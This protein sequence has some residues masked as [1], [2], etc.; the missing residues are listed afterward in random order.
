MKTLLPQGFSSYV[1]SLVSCGYLPVSRQVCQKS[2]RNRPHDIH[3]TF[4][5]TGK[6]GSRG[7]IRDNE[8]RSLLLLSRIHAAAVGS[9]NRPT[10]IR[11]GVSFRSDRTM[12]VSTG[13]TK[14]RLQSGTSRKRPGCFL[15]EGI[16]CVPD[17]TSHGDFPSQ[18]HMEVL[19]C[20]PM[21]HE[22]QLSNPSRQS[23]LNDNPNWRRNVARKSAGLPRNWVC[24]K[25]TTTFWPGCSSN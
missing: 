23:W 19:K 11:S 1:H 25:R 22:S 2:A 21:L 12:L 24:S 3:R 4:S 16:F 10:D 9:P 18:V 15:L 5:K 17:Q 7:R 20:L 13:R 6:R 14:L 8:P